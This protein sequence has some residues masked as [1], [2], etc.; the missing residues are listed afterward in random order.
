MNIQFSKR[1][2]GADPIPQ[3]SRQEVVLL[4]DGLKSG[5][6]N[7]RQEVVL[8]RIT[9]PETGSV[10]VYRKDNV[11]IINS[12]TSRTLLEHRFFKMYLNLGLLNLAFN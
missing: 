5:S 9:E 4:P 2:R 3:K 11:F 8:L 1:V 6:Q 7:Q 12:E 10:L